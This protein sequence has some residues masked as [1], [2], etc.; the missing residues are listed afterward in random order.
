MGA[1][2]LEQIP[3][4]AAMEVPGYRA[5]FHFFD[6]HFDEILRGRGVDRVL[7]ALDA[8]GTAKVDPLAGAKV[9]P[10]TLQPKDEGAVRDL[11]VADHPMRATRQG[12]M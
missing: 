2:H 12:C 7:T 3:F 10:A 9:Q 5:A 8:P 4:T 6:Q 1:V 11:A